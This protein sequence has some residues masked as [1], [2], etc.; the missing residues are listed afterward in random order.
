MTG[1]AALCITER[2]PREG[3]NSPQEGSA[4]TRKA[5]SCRLALDSFRI[6]AKLM[7]FKLMRP[8]FLLKS[9]CWKICERGNSRCKDD[10][11]GKREHKASHGKTSHG[12]HGNDSRGQAKTACID[13]DT[14]TSRGEATQSSHRINSRTRNT[15]QTP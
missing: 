9:T 15:A 12:W 11:T 10:G 4:L 6:T 5:F 13:R 3:R 2:P 1:L 14:E 7:G 8:G